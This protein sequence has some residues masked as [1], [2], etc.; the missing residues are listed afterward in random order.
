MERLLSP[1]TINNCYGS[2]SP[3]PPLTRLRGVCL[4]A[5]LNRVD[6]KPNQRWQG[7]DVRGGRRRLTLNGE[8]ADDLN[9]VAV[10]PSEEREREEE[11]N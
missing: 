10:I 8:G 1:R 4:S 9:C 6:S 11:A 7:C 3:L 2:G 5:M